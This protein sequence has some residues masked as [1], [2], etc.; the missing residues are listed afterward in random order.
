M[1]PTKL[2]NFFIRANIKATT[3]Y[4]KTNKN[5]TTKNLHTHYY[6]VPLDQNIN[7]TVI[8][9]NKMQAREIFEND[10]RNSIQTD[11]DHNYKKSIEMENIDL[12]KF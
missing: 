2:Y 9:S 1:V 12:N 3:T 10:F 6:S 11:N 4:E 7:K 5:R 8:A